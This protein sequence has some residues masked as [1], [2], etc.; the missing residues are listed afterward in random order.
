MKRIHQLLITV[1]VKCSYSA[2]EQIISKF[3]YTQFPIFNAKDVS[4]SKTNYFNN[5]AYIQVLSERLREKSCS[6]IEVITYQ[7]WS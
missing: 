6:K 3:V 5:I 1:I 2:A 4:N 7:F